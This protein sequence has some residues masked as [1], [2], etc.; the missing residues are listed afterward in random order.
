L[1]INPSDLIDMCVYD[2]YKTKKGN[3]RTMKGQ[4]KEQLNDKKFRVAFENGKQKVYEFEE[5]IAILNREDEEDVE[6]WSFQDIL[7]HRRSKDK[8]R[9]GK[10]DLLIK[11]EEFDEPCWEPMEIFKKDD[12]VTLARYARDHNLLAGSTWKWA[13]RYVKPLRN[14]LN[15]I[16]QTLL[17]RK[18]RKVKFQ[19]G[20]KVL[21]MSMKHT[22]LTKR[23]GIPNGQMQFRK[24]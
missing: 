21:E 22:R 15:M 8:K 24:K 17:K 20:F 16:R 13:N 7:S 14:S 18:K 11:W 12:P 3:E 4:V 23:M 6:R 5:L 9:K 2:L 19:Y 10:M 1:E